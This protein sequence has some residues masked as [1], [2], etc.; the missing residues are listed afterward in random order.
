MG[1]LMGPLYVVTERFDPS[2]GAEWDSY[3]SW[4]GLAQ[5]TEVVSL[6]GMLCPP[7]VKEILPAD[8][9]H[10]VNESFMLDYYVDLEYLLHRVGTTEGRNLLCVF[11][12]PDNAPACPPG[13]IRFDFEGY[14]LVDVQGSNSALTNC[15]GF[16]LAFANHE[17]SAHGLLTSLE[18]ANQVKAD[19]RAKYPSEFHAQCHVWA[20]FR[21]VGI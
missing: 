6:D 15:E 17:L 21:A 12:N 16:P 20:I 11:R 14:D 9:A 1:P 18:R 3:V 19:L 8:W 4:S 2:R 10:I 13:N 7:V 5:V